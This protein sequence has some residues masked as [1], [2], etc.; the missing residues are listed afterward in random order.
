[1]VAAVEP[2]RVR[3]GGDGVIIALLLERGVAAFF[4]GVRS[5][6]HRP[7][8]ALR[9]VALCCSESEQQNSRPSVRN[10][11]GHLEGSRGPPTPVTER[12]EPSPLAPAETPYHPLR[13]CGGR[14]GSD[15]AGAWWQ[16]TSPQKLGF[17]LLRCYKSCVQAKKDQ[18]SLFCWSLSLPRFSPGAERYRSTI[19]S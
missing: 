11:G 18:G 3:V 4:C 10:R 1:M 13:S 7:R 17:V 12:P 15:P 14:E 16:V 9:R 5:L 19:Q 2:D 8:P 6:G